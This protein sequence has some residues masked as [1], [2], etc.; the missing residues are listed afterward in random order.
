MAK[1]EVQKKRAKQ[2][3]DKGDMESAKL[4]AGEAIRL[5]K[6]SINQTRM[7]AK[8]SA[9]GAKLESASR[10]NEVSQ[11]IKN[12][13]PSLTNAL[14]IM[15]SNKISE[16]MGEFE[17]V[18]ED[19]DVQIETMTGA[20]DS[21]TASTADSVAVDDLIAEMQGAAGLEVGS[22]MGQAGS[23]KIAA[24]QQAVAQKDEVDDMEAR[25]AAL[26]M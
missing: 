6:E 25:L 18:F 23:T 24:P 17:K 14:K 26:R 21:V 11:Q 12:A 3:M 16:N 20:M 22:K 4:V 7:G 1:A 2:F 5:K 9:V 15:K 13:V 10:M 8:L 19:L